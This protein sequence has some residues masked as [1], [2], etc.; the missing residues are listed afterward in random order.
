[1][2]TD[3]RPILEAPACMAYGCL[4]RM[5]A[6]DR[7]DKAWV[8]LAS[9]HLGRRYNCSNYQIRSISQDGSYPFDV[10]FPN[11]SHSV[12]IQFKDG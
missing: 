11:V 2:K 12:P 5:E 9:D 6:L 1:M 10:P 8:G 3:F 4:P 7:L